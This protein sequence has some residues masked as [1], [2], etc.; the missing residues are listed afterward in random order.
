MGYSV[1]TIKKEGREKCIFRAVIS[2]AAI[3][4]LF[5]CAGIPFIKYIGISIDS[6]S[7]AGGALLF[8]IGVQIMTT[9]KYPA[10]ETEG[11]IVPIGTPFIA[12]PGAITITML[13]AEN[14]PLTF[15]IFPVVTIFAIGFCLFVTLVI[16]YYSDKILRFLREEVN[17]AVAQIMGIIIAAIGVEF[18]MGGVLGVIGV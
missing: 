14:D 18:I 6:F 4:I 16:L 1:Y 11:C 7:I 15:S 2:A 12:G 8:I 3:L 13:M 10:T 17:K 5:A 9:G